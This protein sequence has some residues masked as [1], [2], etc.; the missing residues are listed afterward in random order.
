M[1]AYSLIHGTSRTSKKGTH[2][3]FV[4]VNISGSAPNHVAQA[5]HLCINILRVSILNI[6]SKCYMLIH[7]C[8]FY[9]L[10]AIF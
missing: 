8:C 3:I 7:I 10:A 2:R 1:G 6:Y 4:K 9:F 5:P